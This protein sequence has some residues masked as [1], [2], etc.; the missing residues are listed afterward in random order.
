M[1]I[2]DII[3]VHIW[4][5]PEKVSDIIK[6]EEYT[7]INDGFTKKVSMQ[8]LYEYFNQDYKIENTERYFNETL[9][10]INKEYEP[11]YV[12]LELSLNNYEDM[13]QRLVNDFK[14]NRDKIR[15]LETSFIV[16]NNSIN[17]TVNIFED[18]ANKQSILLSTLENFQSIIFDLKSKILNHRIEIE[19]L[20]G[21]TNEL[22]TEVSQ[23]YIN[24]GNMKN[25]LNEIEGSINSNIQ[26]K[27]ETLLQNINTEY[28]KIISIIDHYHH[29]HDKKY[30]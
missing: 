13:V 11:K 10:S 3:K 7:I 21:N 12:T 23:L 5:L 26:N 25:Q 2:N 9:Y 20:K 28:D 27:K 24:S 29:I 16:F 15:D 1:E 6:E 4:Q 8:R 22:I 18:L 14:V 19:D 30:N 17:N